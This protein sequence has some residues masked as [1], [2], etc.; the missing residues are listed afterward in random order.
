MDILYLFIIALILF[1]GFLIW[2]YIPNQ[3]QYLAG[4]SGFGKFSWQY[5]K[6]KM[7]KLDVKFLYQQYVRAQELGVQISFDELR[8]YYV[9]TPTKTE[10][11]INILIRAK[12]AGV[13]VNINELEK[14][15]ISGGNPEQLVE[16]LKIVKNASVDISRDVLEAHSLYGRDIN[17]LVEII[18]RAKKA[19][20][21]LNL[22]ELVEENLPDEDLRNIVNVLIKAHKASLFISYKDVKDTKIQNNNETKIA[23]LRVS[24]KN[25][26]EHYRAN[27]DYEKYVNAMILAKKAGI[28]IDKDSL[29]IHYLTDGDMEKLVSSMIKAEKAQIGITQKELVEHNIEGRDIGRIVKYLIKA[30]QADLDISVEELIDF[31][32]IGGDTEDFVKALIIA[33]K[34]MLDVGKKELEEHFLAGADVLS[35]VKSLEVI[36]N[37]PD[38]GI[39][40]DDI[41][42][43]YIKGGDVFKVLM[44]IMYARKNNVK[45]SPDF[46]FKLDLVPN[47]NLT[48]IIAWAVNPQVVD[49]EPSSS[50][51]AKDGIQVTLKIRTT[52]RGKI[53]LY[54]KGSKESVL[55]GRIHEAAA[56]EI[57]KFKTYSQV[58]DNLNII[59]RNILARLK[60]EL[61]SIEADNTNKFELEDK[62]AKINLKEIEL[63]KS[64]ALEVLDINIYDIIIGKDTLADFK[65]HHAE[66]QKHIAEIHLEERISNAEAEEAEAKVRLITAKAKVQE[67]MAEAF[68][69]GKIDMS[70]YQKEKYIFDGFDAEEEH[71]KHKGRG[72][73]SKKHTKE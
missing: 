69:N 32:R 3:L 50:I 25:I 39:S 62:L 38:L 61:T 6:M 42:N 67:G 55:F 63:N 31:H 49:V 52:I 57:S 30:K 44:E 24:Q 54:I 36:K 56:D 68:K 27:I 72:N 41:N 18:L 46:A 53:D 16:A 28:E 15:E 43:H 17:A 7:Q 11:M 51:V 1:V 65:I 71:L 33:K 8:E 58:L 66:H 59:S 35:Y 19:R 14:F 45:I 60:G 70:Q 73:E 34:N 12:R 9:S 5:R 47:Y 21:D 26:L 22:L 4:N 48:E 64:S 10:N 29:N 20:I 40:Q 13:R 23:D 2:T 37:F